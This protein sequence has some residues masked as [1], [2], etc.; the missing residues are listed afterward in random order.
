MVLDPSSLLFCN[1]ASIAL[2]DWTDSV[3]HLLE[4]SVF[5]IKFHKRSF[6]SRIH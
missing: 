5:K 4:S 6:L 1:D 2:Q 3:M